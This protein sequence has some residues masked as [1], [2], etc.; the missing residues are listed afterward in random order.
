MERF[1]DVALIGI[2][3]PVNAVI[4]LLTAGAFFY[5][6]GRA[7][8][9]GWLLS[10]GWIMAVAA[11]FLFWQTPRVPFVV[12]L[13]GFAVFL[14]WWFRQRPPHDRAWDP[15]F[16]ELP[17]VDLDS[18]TLK[19]HNLRNTEYRAVDDKHLLAG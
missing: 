6:V 4:V 7:S 11:A 5:D 1:V 17:R 14:F 13:A 15:N 10:I 3:Y 8:I 19:I 12:L 16:T 2:M 9:V 18:D